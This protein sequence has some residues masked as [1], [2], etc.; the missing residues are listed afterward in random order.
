MASQESSMCSV[1]VNKIQCN[2]QSKVINAENSCEYGKVP[3]SE[4]L[5]LVELE[6]LEKDLSE[7]IHLVHIAKRPTVKEVIQKD[8]ELILENGERGYT[9]GH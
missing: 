1:R 2:Q 4:S 5:N 8:I 7:F 9:K 3:L 6:V